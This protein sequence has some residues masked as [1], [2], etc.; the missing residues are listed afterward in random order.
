MEADLSELFEDEAKQWHDE[1]TVAAKARKQAR[2][3]KS[4]AQE[5]QAFNAARRKLP[6]KAIGNAAK[7][8]TSTEGNDEFLKASYWR[9]VQDTLPPLPFRFRKMVKATLYTC[10]Y[11]NRYKVKQA[12]D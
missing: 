1:Q 8:W 2:R 12:G 6:D 9:S 3:E 5:D 7:F 10:A 11:F 4:V